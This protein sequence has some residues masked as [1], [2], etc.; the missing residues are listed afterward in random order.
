MYLRI[1]GVRLFLLFI[2]LFF[3]IAIGFKKAKAQNTDYINYLTINGF[4]KDVEAFG[5]QL[6]IKGELTD[7]LAFNLARAAYINKQVNNSIAW[8][9]LVK[10]NNKFNPSYRLLRSLMYAEAGNPDSAIALINQ[11]KQSGLTIDDTFMLAGLHLL[12]RNANGFKSI[13]APD[14]LDTPYYS[15][16]ALTDLNYR[17]GDIPHKS[18]YVAAALSAIIPGAGKLYAK[19]KGDAIAVFLLHA[20]LAAMAYEGYYRTNNIYNWR[21]IT[22]GSLFAAYYS[23]NIYGSVLAVKLTTY[24]YNKS[25]DAQ[26]LMQL[27]MPV[28]KFGF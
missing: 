14:S 7:S 5:R 13:A 3:L 4:Y 17:M 1:L 12:N 22:F 18:P 6:V 2:C 27:H 15:F 9:R 24:E 23:V 25:F 8:L 26:V 11:Y 16:S 20:G 21:T 28:R 19:R 10:D